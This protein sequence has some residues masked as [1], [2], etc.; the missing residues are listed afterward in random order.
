MV[1]GLPRE[2]GLV[3]VRV[4]MLSEDH[5]LG[6][7]TVYRCVPDDGDVEATTVALVVRSMSGQEANAST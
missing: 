4:D 3:L 1:L 2:A 6:V 7:T 5:K